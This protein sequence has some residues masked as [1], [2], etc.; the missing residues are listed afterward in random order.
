MAYQPKSYRKFLATSLSA[1]VVAS[2]APAVVQQDA[3]A[4]ESFTD[5]SNDYWASEEIQRLSDQGV[6]NGY[7]DGTYAP[8][9]EIKRGQVAELLVRA[10]DLEVDEN[11]SAPFEDLTDDSYYTPYAAAVKEAGLIKGRED[12]TVFAGGMDLSRQQMATILVRAFDLEDKGEDP[13]VVDIDEANASHKE[14]IEILAQY[15]ITNTADGKFRPGETVN[16]AQFAV[17]LDR[18]LE[19]AEPTEIAGV[20]AL[21]EDGHV[22]QVDFTSP[23]REELDRSD[24]RIFES[25]S[26]ERVGV[27][28]VELAS[29]G[30]SAEI[31]LYDD[32]DNYEIERLTEY[33]IQLGDLEDTFVRP[34][35]LDDDDY[36]RVTEVDSEEREIEV[37]YGDSDNPEAESVTLDVPEDFELNFQEALGQEIR[38]WFDSDDVVQDFELITHEDVVYDAIEVNKDDEIETVDEGTKYDLAEDVVFIVNDEAGSDDGEVVAEGQDEVADLID[39]EYDYAKIIFDDNGDVARVYAYDLEEDPVLVEEV[40]GNYILGQDDNELDLED[41]IIV[42]DGKQISIDDIEEGDLVFFNEDAYDGDGF[43]VVYNNTVTGEIENVFEDSFEID[44]ERY[45]YVSDD[46]VRAK[47]LDEDGD[48]EDLDEDEAQEL[49]AGGEVTLY[50]NHKG[51][52]VYVTGNTEEV[53]SNDNHLYLQ[54]GVTPYFDNLDNDRVEIEGVNADGDSSLYDFALSQL[55]EITVIDGDSETEFRVNRDFPGDDSDDPEEVDEFV[56]AK[57]FTDNETFDTD[58]DNRENAS[59]ILAVNDD[60]SYAEVVVDLDEYLE[61]NEDND[62]VRNILNVIEDDD[63][64]VTELEFNQNSQVLES[65]IDEDDSFADGYR[66]QDSTVVYDVS[67]ADDYSDPDTDDVDVTTWG[68]LKEDGVDIGAEEAVIYYDEDG[69][70]THIVA[71]EDT[72]AN[73]EDVY[74]LITDVAVSDGDV[75][76]ITALVEGEEVTYDVSDSDINVEEGTLDRL[77]I[78]EAGTVVTDVATDE[79][80]H[81][82][83]G[84]VT[85]VSVS[86]NEIEVDGET[87]E[88]EFTDAVYDATDSDEDDWSAESLRDI[89]VGD[90]VSVALTADNSRFAEAVVLWEED[91]AN[92]GDDS[93]S[94]DDNGSEESLTA[95]TVSVSDDNLE[96]GVFDAEEYTEANAEAVDFVI[97]FEESEVEAGDTITV[98]VD[99]FEFATEELASSDLLRGTVTSTLDLYGLDDGEYTVKA[100]VTSGD[101]TSDATGDDNDFDFEIDTEAPTVSEAAD[102]TND[103][104]TFDVEFSENASGVAVVDEGTGAGVTFDASVNAQAATLNT[105]DGANDGETIEFTVTDEAGNEVTYTATWNETDSTWGLAIAE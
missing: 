46:E 17:F 65:A 59:F 14:N 96:D 7:P 85:D 19:V 40:D 18:A 39:E 58:I 51:D 95:P 10:F 57:S 71:Y 54:D 13:G 92:E 79:Y 74:A 93:G 105:E 83:N 90:E 27:E 99:G 72:V 28:S 20:S 45:D 55:D 25:A 48:F 64:N 34:A 50:L 21:T 80:Y 6:I 43:A 38:V 23:Y 32:E 24:I 49:Q 94:G 62:R 76:R 47:Y 86:N 15:G 67:D 102:G 98:T 4:A 104:T 63:G 100:T 9:A 12:N 22:L 89:E 88:L 84:I 30:M 36:A 16:R 77:T 101:E 37:T 82:G 42:K 87:Y 103:N 70:V 53:A 52:L 26:L 69:N 11:A 81:E 8:G 3:Q 68:E 56:F 66:L 44:G 31:V 97:D 5:V 75:V 33:T 1:A 60:E 78:N 41:Y 91:V 35:Y 73:E 61:E 29:D 2:A